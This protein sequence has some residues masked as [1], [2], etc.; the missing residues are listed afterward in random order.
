M[1]REEAAEAPLDEGWLV[2]FAPDKRLYGLRIFDNPPFC[3]A[4]KIITIN[5]GY[6]GSPRFVRLIGATKTPH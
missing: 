3:M 4:K 6:T 5:Y 1:S 2:R